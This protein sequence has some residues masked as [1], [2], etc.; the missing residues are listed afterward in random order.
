MGGG[1]C[2]FISVCCKWGNIKETKT[3]H[4]N[5]EFERGV[6]CFGVGGIIEFCADLVELDS[7][8]D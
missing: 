5:S 2:E 8:T 7:G 6:C 4:C 3:F 1:L